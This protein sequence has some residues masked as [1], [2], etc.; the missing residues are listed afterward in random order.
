MKK[1]T[2]TIGTVVLSLIGGCALGF[3]AHLIYS[4]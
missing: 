2:E 1:I 3:I 4:L